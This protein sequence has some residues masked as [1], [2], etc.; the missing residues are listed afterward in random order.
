VGENLVLTGFEN[1][2]LYTIAYCRT[3]GRESWRADA[4][5]K[6]I[7][8]YHKTEGSPAASTS[9]TDG[10]R[11]V[12][13]FGSCGLICYDLTGKELW[14]FELPAV[15]LAGDFG[16]GVSP[17]LADGIVVLVRDQL[18]DSKIY[19]VDAAT[20]SL[21]WEAKRA[22]KISYCT[23]VVWETTAGKQIAAAG[24]AC[25]VGY[26]LQSG[27]EQWIVAALP[28]GCCASPITID[29]TLYFA[30]SGT[31]TP[32]DAEAETPTFDELL[33]DLDQ[34][35]DGA[36]SRQEAEEAFE[37]FF[38]NQDQNKDGRLTRDEWDMTLKL[39]S[40]GQN[41]AFAL[42]SGG[43]GDITTSHMLW[44]QTKGLPYIPSVLVYNGQ[45]IMA[46]DGGIVTACDATT[47]KQIY[48]QR[49]AA[50]GRYYASPIAANGNIYLTALDDGAITV[51]KS[52]SDKADVL[53][54]NEPLGERSAA[55]PAIADNT[56]FVRT[57]GHLYAFEDTK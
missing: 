56:L 48:T 42:K 43:T 41:A 53:V 54:K 37:G 34:D 29:G 4:G 49:A 30:G 5:A 20:G 36:L 17:I 55:T 10:E 12:S 6:Q 7:E 35:K 28:S 3:D 26:D 1:G 44:M 57:A 15:S 32:D 25:M 31:T 11:I 51:L 24:H 21:R 47:G 45:V 23:P 52:G 33:K 2:K 22:S 9:V 38:D 14:R 50:P 46:K 16:S 27:K 40:E 19:A 39:Y 8:K 18:K 13:Y